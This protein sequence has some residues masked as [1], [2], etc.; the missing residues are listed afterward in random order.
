MDFIAVVGLPDTTFLSEKKEGK[1]YGTT[2]T[3]Y[4]TE[5]DAYVQ[6]RLR[7]KGLKKD[8]DDQRDDKLRSKISAS[9]ICL[10][11]R[12]RRRRIESSRDAS[13][14]PALRCTA[15]LRRRWP[16]SGRGVS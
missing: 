9:L 13:S 5:L 15:R 11:Y 2:R 12:H 10:T 6:R 8:S 7:R 1:F 16:R 4:R 3:R 14:G